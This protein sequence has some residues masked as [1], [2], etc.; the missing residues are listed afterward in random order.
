MVNSGTATAS[1][2]PIRLTLL[3]GLCLAASPLHAADAWWN[4]AWS[5]RQPITLDTGT[6][7][8]ALSES[9][10]PTTVLVRL[11]DANFHFASAR[12]NGGDLRM[13]AA[14]ARR[15]CPISWRVMTMF[16]TKRS[17]G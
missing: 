16:S 3:T 13:I 11:S 17:C 9:T 14:M 2:F 10:G 1:I 15:S 8:A 5:Q 7:A 4:R 6:G 12:D